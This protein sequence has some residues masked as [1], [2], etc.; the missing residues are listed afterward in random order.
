MAAPHVAPSPLTAAPSITGK[1]RTIGA[2]FTK[3][4]DNV[5]A[6][7][8]TKPADVANPNPGRARRGN[9]KASYAEADDED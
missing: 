4:D 3:D 2:F 9:A 7:G 8:F 6:T 5:D 1:K